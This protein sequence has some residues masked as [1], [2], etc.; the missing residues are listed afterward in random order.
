L[1]L[2]KTLVEIRFPRHPDH[3]EQSM[4]QLYNTL[5]SSHGD[6]L[7]HEGRMLVH[8][9][10]DEGAIE[11]IVEASLRPQS[12]SSRHGPL[13]CHFACAAL[14]LFAQEEAT[15]VAERGGY[16]VIVHAMTSHRDKQAVQEACLVALVEL[17]RSTTRRE[18][19]S[20]AIPVVGHV[21]QAVES[22]KDSGTIYYL[23][24]KAFRVSCLAGVTV[25]DD[26]AR[27]AQQCMVEGI[28]IFSGDER[29]AST[30]RNALE[31]WVGEDLA[32]R[33]ISETALTLITAESILLRAVATD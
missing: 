15:L 32:T 21:V 5:A 19:N 25:D 17:A 31:I 12:S 24:C 27:R 7:D 20:K 6:I 18:E 33:M 29:C 10:A 1:I 28:I 22:F 13:F 16:E 23:A 2:R 3:A 14:T 4:R 9:L 26:L 11:T 8:T 30:G